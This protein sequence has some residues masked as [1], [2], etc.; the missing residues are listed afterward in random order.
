M[1]DN[2]LE[3]ENLTVQYATDEFT[4][5][6]VNGLSLALKR[7]DTL[8]LV[9]ETG[10]GKTTTALSIM[11]LLPDGTGKINAGK[12]FFDG[13]DLTRLS[14]RE[15][16]RFRG[17]RISMIYQ[18]PMTSL[19]PTMTIGRQISEVFEAHA[20]YPREEIPRHTDEMLEMVGI[21]PVR[22]KEYAHQFSGGM[23]QRVVITMAL[24]ARPSLIIADEPTTALDVTIQAQVLDMMRQLKEKIGTS[25]LLITHDLGV[26]G[27]NCDKVLIMYAG[28]IVET[29]RVDDIFANPL[30]PYTRGLM[31]SVP[32]IHSN[33]RRLVP[34]RGLMPDP[35]E[36][37]QGCRFHPRC[38]IADETCVLTV[39]LSREKNG[40][41]VRCHKCAFDEV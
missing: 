31:N 18:D 3:I 2:I 25:M 28:E 27:E 9:G 8:G 26:V 30:H 4:V 1:R 33:L 12:I 6:A 5:D 29:G 23:K 19:N 14:D 11:G 41:M 16:D 37:P 20:I 39:P 36:L 22:Q 21:D 40:H 17:N 24:A 13:V 35:T 10:A 32:D 15:M 7:G 38:P 34:I